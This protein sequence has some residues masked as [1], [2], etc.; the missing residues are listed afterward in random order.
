MCAK[1]KEREN[2]GFEPKPCSI[3]HCPYLHMGYI[4]PVELSIAEI[5]NV[6]KSRGIYIRECLAARG[7]KA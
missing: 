4:D 1:C 7:I 5:R 3:S 2:R 6:L